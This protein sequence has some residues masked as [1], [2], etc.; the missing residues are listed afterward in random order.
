MSFSSEV[1]HE[2]C[3]RDL[4]DL[5]IRAQLSSFFHLNATM[6][7]INNKWELQ[8]EI[9]NATIAK[10]MFQLVKHR[11]DAETELTVLKRQNFNK[12]NVFRLRV[13]DKAMFILEDLGIYDSDGLRA[14]PLD[15][16]VVQ[17]SFAQA[18]L[19]GA[20]LASGSVNAP[21]RADYHLEVSSDR[22]SLAHFMVELL[23]R[24]GLSAKVTKRRSKYVVYIKKAD[25][26]ADFLKIVGAYNMTMHFEDV[27]I[28]RDFRNSLTRLDNM[29]LANDMK[30]MKAGN[31]QMDAILNLMENNRF[32][33]MDK[34]LIYA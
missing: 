33:H 4:D 25:H 18:Y 24:F 12:G 19:A 5:A 7:I 15:T 11:Y 21:T 30:T 32:N 17:E 10:R 8:I 9:L 13:K 3:T 2:I 1:K 6:H 27:R 31:R 29:E 23:K 34:K 16:I 20:F 22:E 28:Q 14:V 26:I